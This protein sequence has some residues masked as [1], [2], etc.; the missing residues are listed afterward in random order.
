M[1]NERADPDPYIRLNDP[2]R[3]TRVWDLLAQLEITLTGTTWSG[4]VAYREELGLRGQGTAGAVTF[5]NSI[6][7]LIGLPCSMPC[8]SSATRCQPWEARNL[9]S[10]SRS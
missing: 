5:R 9:V 8:G 6:T 10:R 3:N 1:P 4:L 7:I 2:V